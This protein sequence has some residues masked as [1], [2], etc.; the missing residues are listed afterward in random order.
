MKS[1]EDAF[2]RIEKVSFWHGQVDDFGRRDWQVQH[3]RERRVRPNGAGKPIVS[4][5]VCNEA[6]AQ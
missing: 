1:L 2:V 5:K 4:K 3:R 6:N